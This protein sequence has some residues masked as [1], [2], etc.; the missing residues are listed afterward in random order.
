MMSNNQQGGSSTAPSQQQAGAKRPSFD[1]RV[2]D[3]P[4][5]QQQA[6]TPKRPG[7]GFQW[8]GPGPRPVGVH[9]VLGCE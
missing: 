1:E 8:V 6:E 5:K 2:G 3:S 4:A 7:S 9:P